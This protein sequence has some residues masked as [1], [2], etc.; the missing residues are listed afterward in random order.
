MALDWVDAGVVAD[1]VTA[2]RPAGHTDSFR[3]VV[4]H[5]KRTDTLISI[6]PRDGDDAWALR[7][8]GEVVHRLPG[9]G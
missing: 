2:D 5:H 8:D 6:Y 4:Q 3:V 9:R 7:P 1:E